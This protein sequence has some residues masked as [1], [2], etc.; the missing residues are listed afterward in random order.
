[1]SWGHFRI[2]ADE[3]HGIGVKACK[4]IVLV[5]GNENKV[6]FLDG[7]DLRVNVDVNASSGDEVEAF[8]PMNGLAHFGRGVRHY[9]Q[10]SCFDW[11]VVDE[12]F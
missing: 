2:K 9:S 7:R 6:M 10:L 5:F 4:L 1:M 3:L 12:Q 8:C 11:T